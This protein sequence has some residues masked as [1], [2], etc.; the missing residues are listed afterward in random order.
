[1][2][3][4]VSICLDHTGRIEKENVMIRN[5]KS[6]YDIKLKTYI[7][8]FGMDDFGIYC[9]LNFNHY[10]NDDSFFKIKDISVQISDDLKSVYDRALGSYMS[11]IRDEKLIEIGIL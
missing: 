4:I 8:T 3:S 1:M 11:G 7:I 6:Y 9:S 2:E 10:N 5:I